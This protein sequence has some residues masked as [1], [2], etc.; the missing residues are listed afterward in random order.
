MVTQASSLQAS[1]TVIS[2]A[3]QAYQAY[4][5]VACRM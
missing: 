2:T 3:G 4:Q 5:A 1:I